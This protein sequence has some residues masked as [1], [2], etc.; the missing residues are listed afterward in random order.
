M[1]QTLQFTRFVLVGGVGLLLNLAVTYVCKEYLGLWYLWAF[2]IGVAAN[3]TCTFFLNSTFTFS[4][5]ER[6]GYGARYALYIAIYGAALAVN[7][8]IVYVLTSHIGV[9]Y[10]LSIVIATAITTSITFLFS[11]KF[12]FTYGE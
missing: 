1:N 4:G 2:L 11:R 10:L 3:W 7:T 9:Y 12:V 8:A 6:S 5:H